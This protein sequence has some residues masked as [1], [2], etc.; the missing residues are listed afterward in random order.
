MF[1][2]KGTWALDKQSRAA[3]CC[4]SPNCSFWVV[5]LNG[6]RPLN[7]TAKPSEDGKRFLPWM[8]RG[9]EDLGGQEE[10]KLRCVGAG[11]ARGAGRDLPLQDNGSW[12][13]SKRHMD[14]CLGTSGLH[15]WFNERH[16]VTIAVASSLWGSFFPFWV[17][18][19]YTHHL[20]STCR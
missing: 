16:S 17:K 12:P 4:L 6:I 19:D 5:F 3:S 10:G 20:P 8:S 18:H 7:S 1:I 14:L 11:E 15:S 9:L 2:S 13:P